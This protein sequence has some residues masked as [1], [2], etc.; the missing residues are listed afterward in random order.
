[1][2]PAITDAPISGMMAAIKVQKSEAWSE[3]AFSFA[4]MYKQRNIATAKQ[5]E[6]WPLGKL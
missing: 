3:N 2:D 1:M 4:L 5:A 6:V